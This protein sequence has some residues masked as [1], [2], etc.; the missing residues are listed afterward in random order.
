MRWFV[1]VAMMLLLIVITLAMIYCELEMGIA[2]W[3]S[4]VQCI[5]FVVICKII[6]DE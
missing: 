1:L 5:C 2:F 4:I 3:L 6:S